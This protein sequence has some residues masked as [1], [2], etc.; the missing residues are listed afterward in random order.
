MPKLF[1][2]LNGFA[3]VDKFGIIA[4]RTGKLVLLAILCANI[5]GSTTWAQQEDTVARKQRRLG[6]FGN[7]SAH[8]DA[9]SN[10]L[11]RI[12]RTCLPRPKSASSGSTVAQKTSTLKRT[13]TNLNNESDNP[14]SCCRNT[15]R[16]LDVLERGETGLE[17]PLARHSTSSSSSSQGQVSASTAAFPPSATATPTHKTRSMPNSSTSVQASHACGEHASCLVGEA[18]FNNIH[19]DP[20]VVSVVCPDNQNTYRVHR[21]QLVGC[22]GNCPKYGWDIS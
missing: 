12:A 14:S 11:D 20:P 2:P 3:S 9:S 8:C 1:P 5:W 13:L 4:L 7:P 17:S 18:A 15:Y 19:Y 21:Q 10:K 16:R 22:K 6:T